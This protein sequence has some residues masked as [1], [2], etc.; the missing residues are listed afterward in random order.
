[1]AE[2][3]TASRVSAGMFSDV[4]R[5]QPV[6]GRTFQPTDDAPGAAPVVLLSHRFWR[7]RFGGSSGVPG[8]TL[9]LDGVA[10]SVVGV[11]PEGLRPPV[12]P[13]AELWAPLAPAYGVS[14]QYR[15]AANTRAIGRLQDGVS[16]ER[17][18]TVARSLG[19]TLAEEY[20][21][22]NT[23]VGYGVHPLHSELVAAAETALW[24]L[25]GAVGLILLIA[26]VNVANLLLARGAARGGELAM[27]AAL[28]A[29]RTRI[30]R[31]LLTESVVLGC[32]GGALGFLLAIWGTQLLVAAG[33]QGTPRLET[34]A[35]DLRV[36]AFTAC[37]ALTSGVLFGALPALRASRVDLAAFLKQTGRDAVGGSTRAQSGLVV[38]Q[39]ALALVLL[40]GSGLL[41]RSL[42]RLQAVD[43]GFGV[44]NRL[45]LTVNL[46]QDGYAERADRALFFDR[47]V[48]RL[49]SLPG[50]LG[51]AA[52]TTVPLSGF[53]ADLNFLIEGEPIFA[54]GEEEAIWFR[55][56]TPGYFD[57]MEIRIVAGR[58]FLPSDGAEAAP[59]VIV[60]ETF[61][62]TK[63]PDGD[64]VGRRLSINPFDEPV[65]REIVGVARD[66]KNFGIREGSRYA[67]YTPH[68]QIPSPF[69]SVVV[70][71]AMDP[72]A[73]IPMLRR[74]IA[75]L[76]PRLAA[77]GVTTLE[78]LVRGA[79]APDRFLALLL[80]LF[81]ALALLLAGVGLY[82]VV[83]YDVARRRRE[84][85]IRMAMGATAGEIVGLVLRGT[86]SRVALGIAIGIAGGAFVT[87]LLEGLLFGV[88]PRDPLTVAGVVAVLAGVGLVAAALPAWRATRREALAALHVE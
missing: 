25:L 86:M 88:S 11:M 30:V 52:T 51:A 62:R 44:A 65:W 39:V 47:L 22:D 56:V 71:T 60:N 34:V 31:Q 7:D 24:V 79:L 82:G 23:G 26:C 10:H 74:E 46:P 36:L 53:D 83:S 8:E 2:S 87:R 78:R 63:F 15:G 1:M 14:L 59:V 28:G 48:G 73:A 12:Q 41:L 61:A 20:P 84:M 6:L 57:L 49:E 4:L 67:L 29:G 40:V 35:V 37:V 75:D 72:E 54:P 42:S 21:E 81:A 19:A 50:I 16:L 43:L 55:R 18:R 85:G 70:R 69:V 33:P 80:S 32:A 13:N 3:L 64:A 66:V 27:R 76:D 17:A 77:A 45:S 9:I 68:E 58:P 38:G 5:V